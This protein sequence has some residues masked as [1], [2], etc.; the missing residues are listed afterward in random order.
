MRTLDGTLG[1]FRAGV[2]LLAT[3]LH[4]PVVPLRIDGLFELKK[5]GKKLSK[6]GTVQVTVGSAVRYDPGTDPLSIARDLQKR[7]AS[8]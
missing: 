5:A 7:L 1:P 3:N 6:P 4:L 2:G 8:L